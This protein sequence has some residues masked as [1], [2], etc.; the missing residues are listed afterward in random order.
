MKNIIKTFV[1]FI[2]LIFFYNCS[3]DDN[4]IIPQDIEIQD[5]VWKGMNAYYYWQN[6][7]PNLADKRFSS[8]TEINDFSYGFPTPEELFETVRYQPGL[9]DKFSRIFD[10]YIAL[11]N[12]FQGIT[13][14]NGMEFELYYEKGSTTN[15]YGVVRYVVPNSDAD[16]KGVLRGMVFSE[17]NG[18]PITKNNYQNLLFGSNT[19]YTINLADF[20]AGNPILNGNSIS[21]E[22]FELQENPVSIVKTFDEGAKKIGYLLYNQFASSYDGQLNT[23]FNYFKTQGVNELIVDLRYN[24]GG[25]V[26]TATYLGSMIA[27]KSNQ[28]LFSQQIWNEK[29]ME[30]NDASNFLNYFT[31]EIRN[32]DENENIILEETINSLNLSSVYFIVTE[33]TASASELV[34]NALSAYIDVNLVG[35]QTVGKQVGS[36][37]LYDSDNLRRTGSNLNSNH[38]YAMQPI[39]LEI[40]NSKGENN[41]DG[42][43]PEV[44]LYEDF[45]QISGN[46]NLGVLGEKSD[47]LLNRTI[48]YITTG[49]KFSGKRK[50]NIKKEQITNSKLQRPFANE[51]YVDFKINNF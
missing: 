14:N 51:M 9:I 45:G 37:T 3:K 25:S 10:D 16:V 35:T 27:T 34:I 19:S 2:V 21:L 33:D 8:Q 15:A 32:T 20:N 29:V 41:P 42:Y 40:K 13:L 11:E 44:E 1:F 48:N 38:T 31:D 47:P 18:N 5:F 30:N 26:K 28:T 6:D 36:I 24:G 39:V 12:Y 22:K 43:I 46:V 23:A 50:I 4:S 49:A 7:V 17:V